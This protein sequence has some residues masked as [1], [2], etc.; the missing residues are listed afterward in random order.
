MKDM[1]CITEK[2]ME[3]ISHSASADRSKVLVILIRERLDGRE[4]EKDDLC[5]KDRILQH[6]QLRAERSIF[7]SVISSLCFLIESEVNIN[8]CLS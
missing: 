8:S 2:G 3:E 1:L 7:H 4:A 6:T 5:K